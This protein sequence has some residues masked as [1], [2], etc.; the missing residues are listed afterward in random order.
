MRARIVPGAVIEGIVGVP[1]DKSIAHR[2]LM[3]AATA[4][5]RSRLT[6]LPVALD[7]ASTARCLAG[8]TLKARPP[9]EAWADKVSRSAER[10]GFT[11]D[12]RFA[13]IDADTDGAEVEVEGDG[14]RGLVAPRREL[15]CGNSGTTMRLLVGLLAAVP[16]PFV[17][18]GDASLRSR[19]MERVAEPLAAMG[20]EVATTEGHAPVRIA[21]GPLRGIEFTT[22]TPSAQVKGAVLLAGTV[23]EGRTTVV[24]RTVTR[25][26]TERALAALGAPVA[27]ADGR[28]EVSSFQQP[29]FDGAVPGDPSSSAFVLAAAALTGGSVVVRDVGVNPTRL[30]FID[31]MRRMGLDVSVRAVERRVGEPVGEIEL[32]PGGD[33]V[34]TTVEPMELPRVI[35]EVP[36]L[37]A[38]ATH[39]RGE[40]WFAGAGEL[41]VKESDRL[42]ALVSVVRGLGGQAAVEG[43]DLVVVGGGLRGGRATS[44]GDHRIAMAAA[45]AALAAEA[46]CE[47]VGIEDAAVSFPGFAGVLATLGARIVEVA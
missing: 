40:T 26:H 6:N 4:Q 38:L 1:G 31:V 27:V 18:T 10:H 2:W 11:W 15:D 20:A 46:A 16:G 5:G 45:V 42:S 21:G 13:G 28:V 41:R 35:D 23:A 3:L 32:A 19:P 37:A 43:D 17:L 47:V 44:G 8:V 25:D 34:G 29:G 7:V 12:V 30:G 36:V 9:L 24:E 39:A 14:R 22:P 33:L